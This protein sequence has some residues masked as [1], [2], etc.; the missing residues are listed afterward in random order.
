MPAYLIVYRESPVRVPA[1][2]DEYHRQTRQIAG[3][4]FK[5]TPL[6]VN[7]AVHPLEGAPPE[8]VIMLQFPTVDDAKAWYDSPAYQAA[9]PHRLK[10]ADYRSIIVEGL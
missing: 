4:D 5:L 9:L 1:E 3:G 2:A 7:G 8:G 10:S 6:V